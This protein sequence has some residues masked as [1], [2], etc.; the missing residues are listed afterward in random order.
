M[1]LFA[2]NVITALVPL[3]SLLLVHLYIPLG[4]STTAL[5]AMLRSPRLWNELLKEL[6]QPVDDES[7]SL[8]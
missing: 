4:K 7:L 1:I 3:M 6:R 8:S 2:F 5:S